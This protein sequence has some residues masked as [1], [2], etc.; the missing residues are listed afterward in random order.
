MRNELKKYL[1][2]VQ[3]IS[4]DFKAATLSRKLLR[5]FERAGLETDFFGASLSRLD[6]QSIEF[7]FNGQDLSELGKS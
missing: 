2:E 7:C 3:A 1:S 4:K 5:A 6:T